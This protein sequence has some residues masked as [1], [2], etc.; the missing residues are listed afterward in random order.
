MMS[1]LYVLISHFIFFRN[2]TMS[3]PM[4]PA[5]LRSSD[6]VGEHPHCCCASN[7]ISYPRLVLPM[8]IRSLSQVSVALFTCD[9]FDLYASRSSSSA[10]I[11][12]SSDIGQLL[13][14]NVMMLLPLMTTD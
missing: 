9:I 3:M 6:S 5:T 10:P 1:I 12:F 13:V 14:M 8:K 7:S 2:E 4:Q 11:S